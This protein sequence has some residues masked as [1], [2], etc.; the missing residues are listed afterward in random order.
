MVVGDFDGGVFIEEYGVLVVGDLGEVGG[1]VGGAVG[2]F[3]KIGLSLKGHF[4]GDG[5]GIELVDRPHGG[6]EM[7]TP[8]GNGFVAAHIAEGFVHGSDD[9]IGGWAGAVGVPHLE[10]AVVVE[11]LFGEIVKF[12]GEEEA[13]AGGFDGGWGIDD[14]DVEF[15]PQRLR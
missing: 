7:Q 2:P 15:F 1:H 13:G 10:D 9:G 11:V 3:H 14:D 5:L 12:A 4:G 8:A 6:Q